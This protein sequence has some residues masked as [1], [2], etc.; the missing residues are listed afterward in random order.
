MAAGNVESG[1]ANRQ[2]IVHLETADFTAMGRSRARVCAV[3]GL[4]SQQNL[5]VFNRLL[6]LLERLC[7]KFHKGLAF[8][9]SGCLDSRRP[10]PGQ[11]A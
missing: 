5:P 2:T 11:T 1:R 10:L 3:S 9:K 7:E 6:F 4:A 8:V